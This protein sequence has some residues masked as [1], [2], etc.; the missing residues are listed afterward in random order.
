MNDKQE[1]LM[2]ALREAERGEFDGYVSSRDKESGIRQLK[3]HGIVLR[4]QLTEEWDPEFPPDGY[5]GMF[6]HINERGNC[7]LY[8]QFKNGN[9]REIASCV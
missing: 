3:R 4:N 9:R 2:D 8:R 5:S 7:T 6:L 1:Q